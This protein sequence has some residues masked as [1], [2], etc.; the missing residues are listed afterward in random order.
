MLLSGNC[1]IPKAEVKTHFHEKQRAEDDS[2]VGTV[3]S[4]GVAGRGKS[5]GL[6]AIIK[7][8]PDPFLLKVYCSRAGLLALLTCYSSEVSV[9]FLNRARRSGKYPGSEPVDV[10]STLKGP[11]SRKTLWEATGGSTV[12]LPSQLVGW[13][14]LLGIFFFSMNVGIRLNIP[15]W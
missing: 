6:W 15:A 11:I 5:W 1:L 10:I 4:L 3:H 14:Y 7:S 12:V 2:N 9:S 8:G 13:L